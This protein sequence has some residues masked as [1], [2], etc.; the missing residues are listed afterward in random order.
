MVD[1]K[2]WKS[3]WHIQ[4][5]FQSYK[6]KA[7]KFLR[8]KDILASN[9]QGDCNESVTVKFSIIF[10]LYWYHVNAS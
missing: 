10:K 4:N 6:N 2:K 3:K 5:T 8:W 1:F 9:S 7:D